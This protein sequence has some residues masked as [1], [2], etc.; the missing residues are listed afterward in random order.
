MTACNARQVG[1]VISTAMLLAAC[2]GI[3][4]R[5]GAD[6]HD[7]APALPDAAAEV[8]S[9]PGDAAADFGQVITDAAPD[10]PIVTPDGADTSLDASGDAAIGGLDTS[11]APVDSASL[12]GEPVGYDSASPAWLAITPAEASFSETAGR[13]SPPATFTVYNVGSGPS[14]SF[15]VRI[16]GAD[17][18]MFVVADNTCVGPLS[19]GQSCQVAVAFKAPATPGT[20][21]ATLDIS[22]SN[23]AGSVFA[24]LLSGD[25]LSPVDGGE[26]DAPAI[27][28]A[29]ALDGGAPPI[30]AGI[31]GE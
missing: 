31:D 6:A 1:F 10:T 26:I 15:S 18:A 29:S 28:D 3:A 17:A 8:A 7:T 16:T 9:V 13:T 23:A 30:D 11:A 20:S 22:V 21:Y 5:P 12:D 25:A 2:G 27:P 24:V 4:Q 19:G 14:G